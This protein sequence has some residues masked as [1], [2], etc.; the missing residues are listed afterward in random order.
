MAKTRQ[1]RKALAVLNYHLFRP[2]SLNPPAPATI[3]T[4]IR[5]HILRQQVAVPPEA[6]KLVQPSL[7]S[8]EQL[9]RL[10]DVFNWSYFGGKL[11]RVTI[12]YSTRM[13]SAGSYIPHKK[14]MRIGRKYHE[15]YPTEIADTLKHEMIH[16]KHFNHD[17]AF[18]AEA[19]RIGASVRA[20]SH[21]LLRKAPRYVYVCPNCKGQFPRQRRFRM[22]SCGHCTTGRNF[23]PRFKLKLLYSRKRLS[24]LT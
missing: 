12:E 19:D 1:Q 24:Q 15:I 9:Y 14:L 5:Q 16:I 4:K 3:H 22:A 17:A 20:K 13:M 23:D 21:P 8:I 10:F 18:K 2:E 11:P 7:P 6:L